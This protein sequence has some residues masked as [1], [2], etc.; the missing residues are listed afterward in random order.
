MPTQRRNLINLLDKAKEQLKP[1]TLPRPSEQ[2][3]TEKA[4]PEQKE[5]P[6]QKKAEFPK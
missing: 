6:N 5:Q 4:I 1:T 3:E 2:Q